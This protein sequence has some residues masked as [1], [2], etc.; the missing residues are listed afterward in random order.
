MDGPLGYSSHS[1]HFRFQEQDMATCDF[2]EHPHRRYNP[3][4]REWVLVS[5]QRTQRPWQGQ[6]E[7]PTQ[8]ERPCYDPRCYMCPGNKRASGHSNPR[9]TG[10][11][12]FDNDFPA[13]LP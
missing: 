5:P 13:L 6:T 8:P 4:T 1:P 12:V 11:Y 3:L 2:K 10:T 7:P 9:Y